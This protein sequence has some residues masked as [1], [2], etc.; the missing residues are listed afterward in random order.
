MIGLI[1]FLVLGIVSVGVIW[2]GSK[3]GSD[4]NWY[5]ERKAEMN[6]EDCS[7]NKR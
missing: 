4:G 7:K 2:C 5:E 3:I 1:V 6:T